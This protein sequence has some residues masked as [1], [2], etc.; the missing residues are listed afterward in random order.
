MARINMSSQEY[1]KLTEA[2][3][4]AEEAAGF[5]TGLITGIILSLIVYFII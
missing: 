5:G 1:K 4:P 2:A 3:I